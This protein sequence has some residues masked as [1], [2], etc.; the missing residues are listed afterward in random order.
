[1]A[2]KAIAAIGIVGSAVVGLPYLIGMQVESGFRAAI[3]EA[4]AHSPYPVTLSRYERGLYSATAETRHLIALD[5]NEPIS[6]DDDGNLVEPPTHQQWVTLRHAISHG[7]RLDGFRLARI[8]NTLHLDGEPGTRLTALFGSAEPLTVTVDVGFD[9]SYDGRIVSPAIDPPAAGLAWSGLDGQFTVDG[10]HVTGAA[11]TDG[12]R[13]GD[14]SLAIGRIS[15]SADL[16]AVAGSVWTG[17]FDSR[18]AS[19]A[20]KGP[21][22]AMALSGL[23]VES[24]TA[25]QDGSLRSTVSFGFDQLGGGDLK[26]EQGRLH[27]IVDSLAIRAMADLNQALNLQAAATAAGHGTESADAAVRTALSALAAGQPQLSIEDL[28]FVVADSGK[29]ELRGRA[30]YV[31]DANLSDFSPLTDVEASAR[32]DAPMPLIEALMQRQV[33][34]AAQASPIPPTPEQVSAQV[35]ATLGGLIAQ[36]LLVVDEGRGSSEL[37]FKA[38]A[39]MVNGKPMGAPPI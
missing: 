26:I 21:G 18:I 11:A 13:L 10:D 17:R 15:A 29:F 2:L 3:A 1:M 30:R 8:I 5:P 38:G 16:I 6:V 23:S 24:I 12:L 28:S 36:G 31:G 14:G 19:I 20:G 34:E 7:P 22:G 39:L 25:E 32:F 9:G 27:V 37:D 35:R 4:P 33:G